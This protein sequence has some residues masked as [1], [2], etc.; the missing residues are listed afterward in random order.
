M[1]PCS[2]DRAHQYQDPHDHPAKLLRHVALTVT[3][4]PATRLE[5]LKRGQTVNVEYYRSGGFVVTAPTGGNGHPISND[6]ATAALARPV[7]APG[8]VAMRVARIIGTVVCTDLAARQLVGWGVFPLR[9]TDPVRIAALPM[10]K[11]GAVTAVL[12][13]TLAG[14]T[15]P[16]VLKGF[17]R[18]A[19]R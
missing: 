14:S 5:P 13:K 8:R 1:S 6:Q 3:A 16:Y 2:Q 9:V 18:L 10:L 15:V 11:V 4:A 19:E 17:W 12:S 7:Q